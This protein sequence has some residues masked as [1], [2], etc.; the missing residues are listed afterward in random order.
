MRFTPIPR[1]FADALISENR[2]DRRESERPLDSVAINAGCIEFGV[3]DSPRI[4]GGATAYRLYDVGYGIGLD[5]AVQQMGG[6]TRGRARPQRVEARGIQVRNPPLVIDLGER[7]VAMGGVSRP[8]VVTAH[9]FEFGV[10]SLRFAIAVPP[11]LAWSDFTDFAGALESAGLDSLFDAELDAL[12][13]RLA[14]AVDRPR[15]AEVVEDYVVFRVN[16]LCDDGGAP[17]SPAVLTDEQLLPL[18]LGERRELA[19]AAR[20]DLLQHRFS[21]YADDLVILTWEN[22]LVVEP[23][24]NDFD[25]EYV[26][27]FA[28]ALLLELRVYDAELDAEL[29]ALYDRIDA[30]RRKKLPLSLGLRHLLSELQTRVA[31]I[32]EVVERAE[33]AFKVLDDVYLARLHDAAL[34]LFRATAW[35]RGIERKLQIF[36]D[37]YS[38]LNGEAIAARSELL[39][40]AIVLL[41]VFEVVLSLIR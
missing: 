36:K 30:A 1:I 40:V 15:R 14:D 17:M 16:R 5:R 21:Y 9:L 38:M 10:C 20:K 37:T 27:E 4:T 18:L 8:V 11:A 32:T 3:P 35:R 24:E 31:D 23:R 29:P 19:P 34:G 28:N 13:A 12:L 41:I 25:V 6:R 22:A 26:L 7:Q 2:R 33:N 39:E